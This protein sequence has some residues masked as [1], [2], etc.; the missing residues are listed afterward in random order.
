VSTVA[1]FEHAGHTLS[2]EEHGEGDRLLVYVHGLLLDA[3][4]NRTMASLLGARGYRVVLLDLLGHGRS[5]MPTHAYEHR[6]EFYGEQVVGLLDHLGVDRAVVG[7][8]SL[9][10]NV[11]LQVGVAAPE[12]V[13]GLICEMP[14]L[15]RGAVAALAEF[16]PLLLALRYGERLIRPAARL[17]GALPNTGYHAL[18]SFK[19]LLARDPRTSAAVLHGLFVGSGCPPERAR[20]EMAV[21]TLVIGHGGDLLHPMNDATALAAELPDARL[22]KA[23]SALEA[24]TFPRRIVTEVA[25]FLDEVHDQV[26]PG[27]RTG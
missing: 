15:E 22:V 26:Q 7:G 3:A 14:V 2:Y 21:P 24:R 25:A 5:D 18:D 10:A 13:S 9:G 12:R 19:K 27:T 20:R 4:L 11:A 17:V 1:S 23:W 16:Y 8:V 6:L